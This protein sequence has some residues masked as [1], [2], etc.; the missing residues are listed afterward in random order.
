MITRIPVK[1]NAKLL[2]IVTTASFEC[3][4]AANLVIFR[5]LYEKYSR[6]EIQIDKSRGINQFYKLRILFICNTYCI[7]TNRHGRT[8]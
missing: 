4:V 3:L 5:Y 6:Y 1:Q 2:K 8:A 7:L